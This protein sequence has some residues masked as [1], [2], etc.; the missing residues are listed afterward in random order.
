MVLEKGN[1]LVQVEEPGHGD[2][3][4]IVGQM[5]EGSL[6]QVGHKPLKRPGTGTVRCNFV[7][8]HNRSSES[9]PPYCN[10]NLAVRIDYTLACA[11][12]LFKGT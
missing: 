10:L 4:L 8:N 3:D 2:L 12:E 7:K 9:T 11:Q 6:Q 5:G 1:V